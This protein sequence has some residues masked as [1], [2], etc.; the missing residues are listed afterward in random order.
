[1][2]KP[3]KALNHCVVP[4][5]VTP[6]RAVMKLAPQRPGQG[7]AQSLI[8]QI[9]AVL[10]RQVEKNAALFL[11]CQ[12]EAAGDRLTSHGARRFIAREGARVVPKHVAGELIEHDTQ[13]QTGVWFA[14]PVP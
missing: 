4:L 14:F 12:I 6:G 11:H 3:P 10:K 9:F 1:M 5:R 7:K 2:R 13:G 8:G